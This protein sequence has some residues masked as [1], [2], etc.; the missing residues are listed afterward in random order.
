MANNF[1]ASFDFDISSLKAGLAQAN[2]L[3]RESESE[4]RAAA[5]GMDD[6]TKSEE[7]LVARQQTLNK[8]IDIQKQKIDSL[9][10][11]KERLVSAMKEEGK[12]S[13]EI[14]A[15][16]DSL[17]KMITN[18]SKQLDKLKKELDKTNNALDKY[19][20]GNDEAVSAA[21]QLRKTV[22]DQ[23]KELADLKEEYLNVSLTQ[24]KSSKAAKELK[25][26]INKL[27][28]ELTENK[29]KLDDTGDAAR[30]LEEGFTVA[31]GAVAGF[32]ANGLTALTSAVGNSISSL[33]GLAEET[34]EYREDMAKLETAFTTAGHSV[35]DASKVYQDFFGILGEEDRSVEA[36]NHLAQM[37]LEM[38]DLNKWTSIT[39]GVTA[40][41][42]DSLPIEGLTE[43]ANETAKVGEITGTLADALVWAGTSEDEFNKRLAECNSEAER[44]QLITDELNG[45]YGESA[46]K[47]LEM[48][49][50]I[51]EAREAQARL[52]DATAELGEKMEPISTAVS[53]GFARILEK[54]VELTE[55]VNFDGLAKKVEDGF[56]YL[57]N[58]ALPAAEKGFK[59]ILDNKEPLTAGV[60]GIA[61][62]FAAFKTFTFISSIV[63]TIK[64]LF[65]TVKAG[66]GIMAAF[67]TVLSLN[68]IGLIVAAITGLVAGFIYLWNTSDGFKQFWLDLW[69][70]IKLK[71]GEAIDWVKEKLVAI[72]DFFAGV[73]ESISTTLTNVWNGIVEFFTVS[74]PQFIA[75]VIQWLQNLP[76][77]VGLLVGT[78]ARYFY[79]LGL[80][81]LE[82]AT[83]TVPAFINKVVEWFKTLP[84][85]IWTW[86]SSAISKVSQWANTTKTNMTNAASSAINAVVEWFS[87]LPGN[88]WTW[89]S[90]TL[91]NITKWGSDM[92]S[93]GR[94]AARDLVDTVESTIE[95]LPGKMLSIGSDLVEGLWDGISSMS[96]WIG[97]K[98]DSFIEGIKDAFTGKDGFD[99]H[100]PSK[101]AENV[102]NYVMEGLGKG[103]NGGLGGTLRNASTITESLKNKLSGVNALAGNGSTVNNNDN[104]KSVVVN[105]YITNTAPTSRLALWK[106]KNQTVAAVKL[107]TT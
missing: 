79:D 27:N 2:K 45:I 1:G 51:I 46:S 66:T 77:N 96:G 13:D 52:S 35:D 56:D 64:T 62:A 37:A 32:I 9:T 25:N 97:R 44:A 38:E 82:F 93:K 98:V 60:I 23:E 36:V 90:N 22:S 74:I 59:W 99:T 102:G 24:G 88:I 95:E 54:A 3:I 5:A 6:W 33:M 91:S 31:K 68:P 21:D 76:Y 12:T 15:A 42:G 48:N 10:S 29:S 70:A 11:E 7:G 81:L 19:A 61:S 49:K 20:S 85:K 43:A 41:F 30:E 63:S 26:Q 17:N 57:I 39:A 40:T 103:F 107:A 58:T 100:S 72:G 84:G 14:A 78:V 55:N 104:S 71:T 47:Y 105:Q 106:N 92:V 80:K 87:K 34:R 53:D 89:L 67:N 69:E 73:G 18:E 8:Q 83:V 16:T 94:Q 101:W 50:S 4:F 75:L 65:T 28:D 86:L